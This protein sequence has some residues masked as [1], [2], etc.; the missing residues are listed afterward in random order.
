MA[1]STLKLTGL[2]LMAV[3][4]ACAVAG[5]SSISERQKIDYKSAKRL[6]PLEVPP[7]LITPQSSERYAVFDQD[8]STYSD[9]TRARAAAR[10]A[11]Q[12]NILPARDGMRI[13]SAGDYR[14]LVVDA[15]PQ[16]LWQPLRE[17]WQETGF[18]LARENPETG[19]METDWA[20]N[21][22]KVDDSWFGS[23]FSFM[24]LVYSL[25]ERDKF[26]T[27]VERG[28]EPGTSEIFISHRGVYQ[29]QQA[30]NSTNL[31]K[32]VWQLR[33]RDPELEAEM[34]YRLMARLGATQEQIEQARTA[35]DPLPRAELASGEG[36]LEYLEVKDSFD[37]AW[38]RVGLALDYIGFTVEDRDRSR[39]VYFVRYND[40]D[41][42]VEQKGLAKLAFWRD[43]EP[44]KQK[45]QIRV[46]GQD[47][48]SEVH[49]LDEA[50]TVLATPTSNRILT[51][52]R[53]ELK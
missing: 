4:A 12:E 53:E 49:V 5:C 51:L 30:Q 24:R 39:G 46:A 44:P 37:R 40:P 34:L 35:P 10:G 23:T 13:E 48:G 2:L 50:G 18:L 9:Y 16:A 15:E 28:D 22:A 47:T 25:N 32:A 7:D 43:K 27:R 26:R 20:E 8:G 1:D 17:F 19:V 31:Q 42:N 38:R 14:W 29:K 52:L 21:R 41:A 11:T 6:P 33:P 36:N 45:F 3:F